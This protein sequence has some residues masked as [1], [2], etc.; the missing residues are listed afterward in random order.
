MSSPKKYEVGHTT[1]GVLKS[2]GK[3]RSKKPTRNL[4]GSGK[5]F[6]FSQEGDVLVL[7][8]AVGNGDCRLIK[9]WLPRPTDNQIRKGLVGEDGFASYF[10]DHCYEQLE[11]AISNLLGHHGVYVDDCIERYTDLEQIRADDPMVNIV[12]PEPLLLGNE[13]ATSCTIN[14]EAPL[15]Q[16][17]EED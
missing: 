10:Q 4:D 14:F 11:S 16:Y 5:P 17:K 15:E 1:A 8:V 9:I 7:M 2:V 3:R 13:K 12:V 6:D